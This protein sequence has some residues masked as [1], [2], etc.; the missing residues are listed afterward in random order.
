[1]F[2]RG[3]EIKT[4]AQIEVMREAGLVVG[5]TLELLRDTVTAGMT[6]RELDTIAREHIRSLG[7]TSNF[8]GYYGFTGV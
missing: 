5:K 2:D 1:M 4:P 3:I 6:T 8:L 7:A